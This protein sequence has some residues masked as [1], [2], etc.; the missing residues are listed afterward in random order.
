MSAGKIIKFLRRVNGLT[1]AE[2]AAI[3][4][5]KK[6]SIQKYEADDV[7]NLKVETIRKLSKHFGLPAAAFIFPEQYRHIGLDRMLVMDAPLRAHYNLLMCELNEE[8]VK[9]VFTYAADLAASGNY[10]K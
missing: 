8:G 10:K 4:D 9:K 2:L 1:Q 5:V 7:P 6:S 3:L